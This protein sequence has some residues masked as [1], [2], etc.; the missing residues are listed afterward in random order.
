MCSSD[1]KKNFVYEFRSYSPTKKILL[2]LAAVG[3]FSIGATNPYFLTRLIRAYFSYLSEKEVRQHVNTIHKLKKEKSVAINHGKNGNIEVHLTA[4][5]KKKVLSYNIHSLQLKKMDH[6]DHQWRI[7]MYD[8]SQLRKKEADAIR[9]KFKKLELYHLQKSV[10][11]YPYPFKKEIEFL[12]AVYYIPF[13]ELMYFTT[14]HI[15]KEKIV[16]KKYVSFGP[17]R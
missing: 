11:V 4:K 7:M 5:G 8:I 16:M 2:T 3:V 15:P 1:L 13:R 14:P 10:W 12:F 6:W 17:K 9:K